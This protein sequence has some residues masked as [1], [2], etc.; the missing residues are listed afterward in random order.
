MVVGLYY[1]LQVDY[2]TLLWWEFGNSIVN[3]NVVN[4]VS[5]ACYWGLVLK[6]VYEKEGI[7]VLEDEPT[8]D[9]VLY[10]H[11]KTLEDDLV[12]FPSVARILDAILRKV[13]PNHP[14]LVAYL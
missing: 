7:K 3:T 6:Y 1:D 11:P 14:V 5:C 12:F 8:T 10:Q 2:A 4:G 13:D 9:F